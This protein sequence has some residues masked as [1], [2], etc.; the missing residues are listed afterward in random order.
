MPAYDNNTHNLAVQASA[1][2]LLQLLTRTYPHIINYTHPLS[3]QVQS[4]L[5]CYIKYKIDK[6]SF[7]LTEEELSAIRANL[8]IRAVVQLIDLIDTVSEE[9]LPSKDKKTVFNQLYVI[10]TSHPGMSWSDAHNQWSINK[11]FDAEKKESVSL[12]TPP[13]D[14]LNLVSCALLDEFRFNSKEG[15]EISDRCFRIENFYQHWLELGNQIA[16]GYQQKCSGGLQ[17]DLLHFLSGTYLDKERSQINAK[18]FLWI[19]DFNAFL[20]ESLSLY[21]INKLDSIQNMDERRKLILSWINWKQEMTERPSPIFTILS[22]N[23]ESEAILYISTRCKQIGIKPGDHSEKIEQTIHAINSLDVPYHKTTLVPLAAELIKMKPLRVPIGK[24]LQYNQLIHHRNEA[25][26]I[27]QEA[28]N[29]ND[30]RVD[31]ISSDLYSVFFTVERLVSYEHIVLLAEQP[32]QEFS[33]AK[34]ALLE[35]LITYFLDFSIEKLFPRNEFDCKQHY[36]LIKESSFIKTIP[37]TYIRDFFAI[38]NSNDNQ[39]WDNNW[40]RI[41]THQGAPGE[42]HPLVLSD[43]MLHQWEVENIQDEKFLDITPYIINRLFIHGLLVKPSSWSTAYCFALD[44]LIKWLLSPQSDDFLVDSVKSN[45]PKAL[46]TNLSICL[47]INQSKLGLVEKS[48]YLNVFEINWINKTEKNLLTKNQNIF[49]IIA[50]KKINKQQCHDFWAIFQP[51]LERLSITLSQAVI[52]F[53]LPLVKFSVQARQNVWDIL[54]PQ[55]NHL[56]LEWDYVIDLHALTIEEFQ[57]HQRSDIWEIVQRQLQGYIKKIDDV[58]NLYELNVQQFNSHRRMVL[59]DFIKPHLS[60]YVCDIFSIIRLLTLGLDQFDTQQRAELVSILLS[61]LISFNIHGFQLK[62]LMDLNRSQFSLEQRNQVVTKL[63]HHFAK[64]D[65]VSK[66]LRIRDIPQHD[67]LIA[68]RHKDH[69]G[70]TIMHKIRNNPTLWK[71]VLRAIPPQQRVHLA[72][73]GND[74]KES[75]AE[76]CKLLKWMPSAPAQYLRT[77]EAKAGATTTH[78]KNH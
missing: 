53:G 34:E 13:S 60:F 42:P 5:S 24:N 8:T 14:T 63:L 70:N 50:D 75:Q 33:R 4:S 17:H 1:Y 72:E 66:N 18:P 2:R 26:R 21:I 69:D 41:T 27:I 9:K 71:D 39:E 48:I 62:Q 36:F 77:P 37:V 51:H 44:R 31:L 58:I 23:W 10:A 64:D 57:E 19:T 32:D 16:K 55:L 6:E 12:M 45:Y 47:I 28:I 3:L 40:R 46:L 22:P 15:E 30:E 74:E 25:L 67:L 43:K 35:L 7:A 61:R 38:I 65:K 49:K 68:L 78:I 73:E 11:W 52:I 56:T 76:N 29:S 54:K 59:W 20:H